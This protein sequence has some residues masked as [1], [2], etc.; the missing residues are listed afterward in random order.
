MHEDEDEVDVMAADKNVAHT[1]AIRRREQKS[2]GNSGVTAATTPR[3]TWISQ[4]LSSHIAAEVLL[5]DLVA[6][7]NQQ[8]Q[9]LKKTW[10]LASEM[11]ETKK[12]KKKKTKDFWLENNE[13][14]RER[15]REKG[16]VGNA[17]RGHLD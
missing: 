16:I 7:K 15:V 13:A 6:D 4:S 11:S 2:L 9:R 12:E 1:R 17:Y 14:R 10:C 5:D 8:L 3:I